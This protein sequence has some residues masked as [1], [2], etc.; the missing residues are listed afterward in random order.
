VLRKVGVD[1]PRPGCI[2]IGQGVARNGLAA[3]T[4]VIESFLSVS[5]NVLSWR[6]GC[7]FS[8]ARHRRA[9]AIARA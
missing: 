8:A 1:L 5:E 3:Q 2:G 9:A 4:H 6:F 7:A